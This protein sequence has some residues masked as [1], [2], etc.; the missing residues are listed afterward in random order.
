MV[1]RINWLLEADVQAWIEWSRLRGNA[2]AAAAFPFRA[3]NNKY[4]AVDAQRLGSKYEGRRFAGNG[5]VVNNKPGQ[6]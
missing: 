6:N 5:V 4:A 3:F 1:K 2:D